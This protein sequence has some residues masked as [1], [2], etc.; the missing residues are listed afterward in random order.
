M[1]DARHKCP[2]QEELK[3]IKGQKKD[4]R[5][6]FSCRQSGRLRITSI[7]IVTTVEIENIYQRYPQLF[8]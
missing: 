5:C 4:P 1:L 3:K 8:S 2:I 7:S 6:K